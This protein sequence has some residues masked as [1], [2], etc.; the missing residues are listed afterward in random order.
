MQAALPANIKRK[1]KS[2][3]I[4]IQILCINMLM[5]IKCPNLNG[6][7]LTYLTFLLL[8]GPIKMKIKK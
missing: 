1:V 5:H 6:F 4:K 8:E 3:N 7:S 2:E